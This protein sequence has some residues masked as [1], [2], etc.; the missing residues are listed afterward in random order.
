MSTLISSNLQGLPL[1]K[2]NISVVIKKEAPLISKEKIKNNLPNNDAL[3]FLRKRRK[4]S[5]GVNLEEL[6]KEFMEYTSDS[7][8][9]VIDL[10]NVKKKLRV[11]KRRLYD[12]TNVLEGK[13]IIIN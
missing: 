3:L 1:N 10:N 13:I 5:Q 7:E 12:V 9:R 11:Q 4:R 8:C 2:K 6:S